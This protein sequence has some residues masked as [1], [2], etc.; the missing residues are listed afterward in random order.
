MTT[1]KFS[2]FRLNDATPTDHLGRRGEITYRDGYLYYHDGV[3]P[4]GEL[5]GSGGGGSGGTTTWTSVTGKPSFA[6]V[7]T[8]GSY[9]DLTGKPTIPTSFS[10]LVNSENT[11]SLDGSGVLTFPNGTTSEGNSIT[12]PVD[13]SLTVNLSTGMPLELNSTF[14]IN[15]ESIKLPTG[16]GIIYAGEET[17]A[18]KWGLDSSNKTLY[19]PD[20]GDGVLPQ[21]NYSTYNNI[22]MELKT[23]AKGVRISTQD[24]F[25]ESN[26]T[27][28]ATGD[29]T[30]PAGGDIVDST[31]TSVLGG[32]GST[33]PANASGYLTNDGSGNLAW[34]AGDGT[35]SGAY[36]DLTGKPTIPADVSDLTDTTS[37]L[38]SGSASWPVTNTA[39]AGGPS[40]IAIGQNAGLTTQGDS[41][42]ALG[43]RAGETTQGN[44]AVAIGEQAGM[45]TQGGQAVAVGL[46]AGFTGQ[47]ARAVAIGWEAGY[48]GQG[49]YSVAIGRLAGVT[50]QA[51][52][53]IILNA[54]GV[55]LNQTTASTFTVAPIRNA[56]GTD[57]VLQYNTTTKEVSYSN[58]ITVNSNVWTFGTDGTLTLPEGGDIVDSTGTTVLGGGSASWP[59]TNTAGASG[60]MNI[61]IGTNAGLTSQGAN[62][63]AVGRDAG[64]T[65]Q[66][67]NAVAVGRDAGE[68]TQGNAA[69]AVGFGAGF[70][71]QGDSA[72]AIGEYTGAISQGTNAVAIGDSAGETSQGAN[73]VAIGANAGLTTQSTEA[74]AVGANAGKTNQGTNSVAV[75]SGAGETE[76]SGASVAIGYQAGQT[77]QDWDAVAIGAEA[78]KTNQGGNA[79]AIGE[80]AAKT[81]QGG[82]AVAIGE[83]TGATTQGA[84]AVAVG[85]AAGENDQGGSAVAIGDSAGKGT[86]LPIEYV[87]GAVSPSTTLVVGGF[88]AA[89]IVPGMV[90]FGTGF[91]S[92][93]TVVTVTDA[94][95]VEISAP[96]DSTP[97]GDLYFLIGQGE[98]A[99]A[100]GAYAGSTTQAANS[101]IINATGVELNQG[102]AG[103]FTVAP[104]RN[105]SGT[106]GVLQYNTTTKEVTYSNEITVN[107]NVWTFG[108]DGALTLPD[109]SVIASY[110]PVTVIAGPTGVQTIS[111]NASA[112]RLTFIES[113]DSVGAFTDSTFTVPYTG[114]YQFNTT[115]YFTSDVTLTDG[116]LVI[117]NTTAGLNELDTLYYGA[118]TGRVIN[119]SSMQYLTAGDTVEL[120]FR[121][122]S[123]NVVDI[124]SSSRL[125]IHRVSIG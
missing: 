16:N 114:Y 88:Y 104:I 64:R 105:A 29:L 43:R 79:V 8:S 30:L 55:E 51:A 65:T 116:F 34:A 1:R 74:V 54:T 26:W 101:I 20:A 78:G 13:E 72:V 98:N 9:A 125:T 84:R 39:G 120:F 107:S 32:G 112:T 15:P 37:L 85:V 61:A 89:N 91:T 4:G 95:T 121:Q 60:P 83:Y 56:S 28:G 27:F 48:T 123:G 108:T 96:A 53:S 3:T 45:T 73:A 90:I 31:G 46:S 99:V 18:D 77:N 40:E 124:G 109:N 35:F 7:A 38:G 103:T 36:A 67:A 111:D 70:T 50:N 62:A 44:A 113:V 75:G 25:N 63:V 115:V 11:F 81:N 19:F 69:V 106:S 24:G 41:A 87:S 58:E 76:Q 122:V 10:S 2:T 118:H 12:I 57:G 102:T 23:Y 82:S 6:T 42:V 59:V 21:I 80:S 5:I 94:T 66:G 22:G 33:L 100:I 14:K 110:K 47:G 17:A 92:G 97:S 52:N 71:G 117:V 49:T 119:G 93:Q 86:T 68:T